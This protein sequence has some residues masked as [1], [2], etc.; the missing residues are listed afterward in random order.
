MQNHQLNY[1]SLPEIDFYSADRVLARDNVEYIII[2]PNDT[3]FI[4][5]ADTIAAWRKL[6]GISAEVFTT[7]AIGGNTTTAIKNFLQTAY[8]TWNPAP[9]AF[10]IL[11]DYQTSG[12]AYGVTSMVITHPWGYP[13]Y[14]SDNWYADFDNDILPELHYGR[15]CA[16]TGIQLDRMV[17]KFLSYERSPYTDAGL[18]LVDRGGKSFRRAGGPLPV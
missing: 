5:W 14:A 1:S 15:I 18:S 12:D 8:K 17:N 3:V 7:T 16:Q 4:R 10:L 11:S 6:Q 9:A 2:V 13:A